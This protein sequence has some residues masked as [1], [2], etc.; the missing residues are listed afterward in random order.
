MRKKNVV[1]MDKGAYVI[2]WEDILS[3]RCIQC[4]TDLGK[5]ESV[6]LFAF[7][8]YFS[9]FLSMPCNPESR[10]TLLDICI[11]KIFLKLVI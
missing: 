11:V 9:V 4:T 8:A 3:P 1:V 5:S 10:S 7:T 2:S 6:I